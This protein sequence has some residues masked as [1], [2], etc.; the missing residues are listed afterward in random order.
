MDQ[1][2]INKALA[3]DWH[4]LKDFLNQLKIRQ[5][6]LFSK[7]PEFP[8]GQVPFEVF[9]N[10][11]K[12]IPYLPSAS[13]IH[14][15]FNILGSKVLPPELVLPIL[16]MAGY[17]KA[18][19]RLPVAHDPFHPDNR[20]KLK[21]YLTFCWLTLVRCNMSTQELKVKIDWKREVLD[22][23]LLSVG[24]P[25][26]EHLFKYDQEYDQD[27]QGGIIYRFLDAQGKVCHSLSFDT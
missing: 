3:R 12:T 19:R 26:R 22:S 10:S 5:R 14:R 24:L 20:E 7:E 11:T 25:G 15:V 23:L 13:D 16:K 2:S 27:R 4:V 8:Y 21:K 6:D 9:L 17:D 1:Y 18:E